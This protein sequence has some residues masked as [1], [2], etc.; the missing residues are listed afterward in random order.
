MKRL[1]CYLVLAAVAFIPVGTPSAFSEERVYINGIDRN[2]PPFSFLDNNNTPDGLD[3][4]A[5]E[6]IGKEMGFKVKHQ[7]VDWESIIAC[8]NEKSI[9]MIAAGMS[10]TD[11]RKDQVN[12]TESYLTIERVLVAKRTAGLSAAEILSGGKEVGVQRG[13]TLADWLEEMLLKNGSDDFTLILYDSAALAVEDVV[14]GRIVAAAIDDSLAKDA[15]KRRPVMIVG[16][17]GMPSEKFAYAVRKEDTPLLCTLNKGLK[18]L[19]VSPYWAELKK[20]Y[21]LE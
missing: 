10:V 8:L 11:E 7:A 3:V 13:S 15:I 16:T 19:M 4:K 17:F 2:F 9:D 18:R 20:K 12:F 1:L 5:V 6:W 21:E 14:N